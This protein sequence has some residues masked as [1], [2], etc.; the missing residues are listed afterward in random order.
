MAIFVYYF[1]VPWID[2]QYSSVVVK[3]VKSSFQN[4]FNKLVAITVNSLA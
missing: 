2:I 3:N 4:K 1:G